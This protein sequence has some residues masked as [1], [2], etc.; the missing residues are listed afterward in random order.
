MRQPIIQTIGQEIDV[1][2][3]GAYDLQEPSTEKPIPKLSANSFR[4]KQTALFSLQ[5]NKAK[6]TNIIRMIRSCP[7]KTKSAYA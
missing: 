2:Q 5:S 1:T 3:S 4:R 6:R 7:C